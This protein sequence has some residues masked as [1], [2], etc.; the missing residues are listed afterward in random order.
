MGDLA[1]V[2]SDSKVIKKKIWLVGLVHDKEQITSVAKKIAFDIWDCNLVLT[3][4]INTERRFEAQFLTWFYPKQWKYKTAL[5][6]SFEDFQKLYFF[7]AV[8]TNVYCTIYF[9]ATGLLQD[10]TFCFEVCVRTHYGGDK[11]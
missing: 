7:S 9:I 2:S 11:G 8:A 5:T 10:H 6:R 3:L 1:T 4:F